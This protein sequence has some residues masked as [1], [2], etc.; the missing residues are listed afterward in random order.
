MK[1]ENGLFCVKDAERPSTLRGAKDSGWREA[2]HAA[3]VTMVEKKF[4]FPRKPYAFRTT[5]IG[6]PHLP[7]PETVRA[8]VIIVRCLL[9]WA[10][11]SK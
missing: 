2:F 9:L 5:T 10:M 11:P 1:F 3:E 4:G 7:T 8:S 6:P